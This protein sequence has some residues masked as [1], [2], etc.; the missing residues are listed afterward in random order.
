MYTIKHYVNSSGKDPYEAWLESLRD[1][2]TQARI[3][4]RVLKLQFGLFGDCKPVG[5]GVWELVMNWGPGYRVYYVID[6]AKVILLCEGGDKSTQKQD[7]K[8]AIRHWQ[9]WKIRKAK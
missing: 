8:R 9:D 2:R 3:S 1:V 4:A 5:E 6:D 7:I